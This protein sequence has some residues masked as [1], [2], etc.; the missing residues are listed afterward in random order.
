MTLKEIYNYI[1]AQLTGSLS[2]LTTTDKSNLV[3]VINEVKPSGGGATIDDTTP[4]LDKVYSSEKTQDE[5]DTLAAN[6]AG[7]NN[8]PS[9]LFLY[10][11]FT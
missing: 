2:S 8:A 7:V 5:I 4:A 9:R 10:Y 11:N 6:V 3:S 1:V